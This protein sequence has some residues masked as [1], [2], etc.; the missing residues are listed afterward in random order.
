MWL[1]KLNYALLKLFKRKFFPII[2][3]KYFIWNI[4]QIIAPVLDKLD[5]HPERNT[6]GYFVVAMKENNVIKK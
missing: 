2:P 5:K 3:I 4:N 6:S 1:L